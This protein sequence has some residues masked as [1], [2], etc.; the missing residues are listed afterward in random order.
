MSIKKK[1]SSYD[2]LSLNQL[3][4]KSC[5]ANSNGEPIDYRSKAYSRAC[6]IFAILY[7]GQSKDE[8]VI[9][10]PLSFFEKYCFTPSKNKTSIIDR[11]FNLHIV[12]HN[13]IIENE[14]LYNIYIKYWDSWGEDQDIYERIS[15]KDAT[16]FMNYVE[17]ENASNPKFSR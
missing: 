8:V 3:A 16:D 6:D 5:L 14:E 15:V 1:L 4:V 7:P 9:E 17:E 11:L 10:N 13:Y 2:A 12:G